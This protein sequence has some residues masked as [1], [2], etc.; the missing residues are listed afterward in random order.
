VQVNLELLSNLFD[1]PRFFWCPNPILSNNSL[2]LSQ[3]RYGE[4]AAEL[5]EKL[6]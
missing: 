4:I 3:E 2:T 1:Y 6:I 5:T